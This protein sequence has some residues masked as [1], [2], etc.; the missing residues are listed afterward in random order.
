LTCL[1]LEL[2]IL[3]L[4]SNDDITSISL[5]HQDDLSLLQLFCVPVTI[6]LKLNMHTGHQEILLPVFLTSSR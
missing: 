6:F 2:V 4:P 3:L 5:S 1:I